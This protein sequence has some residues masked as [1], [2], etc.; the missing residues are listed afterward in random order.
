MI[1]MYRWRTQVRGM[2]A[3]ERGKGEGVREAQLVG[4]QCPWIWIWIW[5]HDQAAEWLPCCFFS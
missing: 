1:T 3:K 2:R 4:A 5:S